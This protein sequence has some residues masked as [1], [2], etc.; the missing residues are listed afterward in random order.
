MDHRDHLPPVCRPDYDSISTSVETVQI[1][2]HKR[3]NNERK[4]LLDLIHFIAKG[5]KREIGSKR[6]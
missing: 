6:V 3:T 4:H 2:K 1:T 5:A